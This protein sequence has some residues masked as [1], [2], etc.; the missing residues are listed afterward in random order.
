MSSRSAEESER[1]PWRTMSA[2]TCL[3][4]RRLRH[5]RHNAG[6]R[7]WVPDL[8]SISCR[9]RGRGRARMVQC[10]QSCSALV[11]LSSSR[12]VVRHAFF[13]QSIT[14]PMTLECHC[15]YPLFHERILRGVYM[16]CKFCPST[17]YPNL[18]PPSANVALPTTQKEPKTE[19]PWCWCLFGVDYCVRTGGSALFRVN[20]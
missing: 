20:H 18:P 8:R 14:E 6:C 7:R 11:G 5:R 9:K 13:L 3:I 19:D 16:A 4:C 10:L 17:L 12:C 1:K 2:W 15:P